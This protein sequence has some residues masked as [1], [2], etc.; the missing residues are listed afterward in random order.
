[1]L[2]VGRIFNTRH[3]N[4]FH[5][6]EQWI[7]IQK[8]VEYSPFFLQKPVCVLFNL[9]EECNSVLH[10]N[11]KISDLV[12]HMASNPRMYVSQNKFKNNFKSF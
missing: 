4:T 12:C 3:C 8:K 2:S 1:M 7:S 6:I 5:K 10:R 9:T 11:N